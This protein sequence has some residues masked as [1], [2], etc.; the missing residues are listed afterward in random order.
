MDKNQHIGTWDILLKCYI[1]IV[2]VNFSDSGLMYLI[3]TL[4]QINELD[5]PY[6]NSTLFDSVSSGNKPL[7]EPMLTQCI[8]HMASLD[9]NKLK[10]FL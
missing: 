2:E 3:W 5:I 8:G 1:N 7:H 9:H 4:N 10:L 6:D